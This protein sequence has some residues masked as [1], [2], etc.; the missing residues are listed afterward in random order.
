MP[1]QPTRP[2]I[3]RC[4]TGRRLLPGNLKTGKCRR[5]I[6]RLRGEGVLRL[7]PGDLSAGELLRDD[8]LGDQLIAERRAQFAAC[9]E[10]FVPRGFDGPAHH[11]CAVIGGPED[12]RLVVGGEGAH[13]AGR[14][15][16]AVGLVGDREAQVAVCGSAERLVLGQDVGLD[17]VGSGGRAEEDLSAGEV[18]GQPVTADRDTGRLV[19]RPADRRRR[20]R[21][22]RPY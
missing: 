1:G 6:R 15:E 7:V 8:V 17:G 14:F 12:H 5:Q 16:T 10:K 21:R 3:G 18:L 9:P 20:R 2:G 4:R 19:W 13:L 22:A 11:E